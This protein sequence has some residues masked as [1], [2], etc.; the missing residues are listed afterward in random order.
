MDLLLKV[1]QLRAETSRL[2]E[3][4][5]RVASKLEQMDGGAG[6]VVHTLFV[7]I[8]PL[9]FG[10]HQRMAIF[11]YPYGESLRPGSQGVGTLG[12]PLY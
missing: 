6:R 11:R 8:K 5:T 1:N 4:L 3:D 12:I 2:T 9:F 10:Q 7:S